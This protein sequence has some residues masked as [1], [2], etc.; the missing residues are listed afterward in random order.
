M[1][2]YLPLF[3]ILSIVAEIL[4]TIGGFG[5]SV[6]FVSIAGFF[7]DFQSVLGITAIFH[8]GSNVT[9]IGAF[10]KGLDWKIAFQIGLPAVAFVTLGAY[11]SKWIDPDVL[12]AL[13]GV[14]LVTLSGV[15]IL[16]KSMVIRPNLGNSLIGGSLSGLLAGLLGTGGAIRGLT[17]TSFGLR[18]D[19]FIATSA[20]ID[21]A[22]DLS[23]TFVYVSNG[24]VHDHD[25]YLIPILLVVSI[26]GTL[27]GKKI[28]TRISQ[29]N[30]RK[31]SLMLILLIGLTTMINFGLKIF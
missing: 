7:L 17:L 3:I 27:T 20:V 18:K 21:L 9:K 22:I 8:L 2:N 28:L 10:R 26:I 4:G 31:T 5:S 29:E 12:E 15:F 19:T 30:F 23:R 16:S 14:F 11:A 6:F 25:L 24:Y 13:L 1:I